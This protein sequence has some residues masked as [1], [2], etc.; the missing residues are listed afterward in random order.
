MQKGFAKFF[1]K[2]FSVLFC[3]L[4]ILAFATLAD[5]QFRAALQGSVV[6]ESGGVVPGATVILTS[7]ETQRSQQTVTSDDGFYR[8]SN[9][10]P[11]AAKSDP[12][13][14][15]LKF[16]LGGLQNAEGIRKIFQ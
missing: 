11:G 14:Y 10:A 16:S 9:L 13:R 8:F 12:L 4:A 5:A 7:S 15:H 6:D 2:L 3:C 1:N